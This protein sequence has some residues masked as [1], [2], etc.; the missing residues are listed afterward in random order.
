MQQ[1]VVTSSKICCSYRIDAQDRIEAV[2]SG[3][4]D[5]AAGNGAPA[6]YADAVIGQSL[7]RYIQ[8]EGVREVY[9]AL[10]DRV[11]VTGERIVV[12]FRCDSPDLVRQMELHLIPAGRAAIHF[13]SALL[14]AVPRAKVALFDVSARRNSERIVVCSFCR[15]LCV[16]GRWLDAEQAVRRFHLFERSVYPRLD[17]HIC[18]RCEL[19]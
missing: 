12:P 2:G 14:A 1:P 8:G 3:W 11:R 7:W 4:L 9:E 6:L 10:F 17:E 5:F 13:E 15:R 19:C 16:D 18:P